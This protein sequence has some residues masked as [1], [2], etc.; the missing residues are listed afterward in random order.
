[1]IL[2]TKKQKPLTENSLKLEGK[3]KAENDSNR[4]GH[5]PIKLGPKKYGCPFCS[6]TTPNAK[7]MKKHSLIHT[8]EKPFSCS[9]CKKCFNQKSNLKTH[10]VKHHSNQK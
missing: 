2:K 5:K 7:D 4:L 10:I 9:F 3:S 6:K 1:M 8:G